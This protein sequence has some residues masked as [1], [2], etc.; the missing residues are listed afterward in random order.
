MKRA[1]IRSVEKQ[2]ALRDRLESVRAAHDGG[3]MASLAGLVQRSPITQ[4]Q[5]RGDIESLG[6]RI[7]F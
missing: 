2:A 5:H 7:I 4:A 1:L 3:D 6:E